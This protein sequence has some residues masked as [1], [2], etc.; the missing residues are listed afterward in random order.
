MERIGEDLGS[1]ES[2]KSRGLNRNGAT[3]KPA[4]PTTQGPPRY[5]GN[6]SQLP[7]EPRGSKVTAHRGS[8]R[9]DPYERYER[10]LKS[11]G[12]FEFFDHAGRLL[13]TQSGRKLQLLYGKT[14]EFAGVGGNTLVQSGS[15]VRLKYFPDT[16][17]RSGTSIRSHAA[18]QRSKGLTEL[19]LASHPEGDLLIARWVIPEVSSS[20]GWLRRRHQWSHVCEVLI[21]RDQV[22]GVSPVVVVAWACRALYEVSVPKSH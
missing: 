7:P 14:Y 8:S 4:I 18:P 9:L 15:G 13:A 22:I 16:Y 20:V 17:V 3:A 12:V 21:L 6:A 1:P 11:R 5:S 10:R 2:R 19:R